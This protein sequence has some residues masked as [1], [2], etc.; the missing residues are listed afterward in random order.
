MQDITLQRYL[1]LLLRENSGELGRQRHLTTEAKH[2]AADALLPVFRRFLWQGQEKRHNAS[3]A[4]F[5]YCLPHSV[6]TETLSY[7]FRNLHLDNV[8]RKNHP[9]GDGKIRGSL[10]CFWKCVLKQW[11][12]APPDCTQSHL[13]EVLHFD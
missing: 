1:F 13:F 7:Y 10:L 5:F 2:T 11:W 8:V 3:S 9:G 6:V 12:P 4:A